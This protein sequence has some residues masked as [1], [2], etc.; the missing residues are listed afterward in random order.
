MKLTYYNN[1]SVLVENNNKKIGQVVKESIE[2]FK[3]DLETQTHHSGL[4]NKCKV[5]IISKTNLLRARGYN[6]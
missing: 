2:E 1:T 5:E 4:G 6:V 3:E